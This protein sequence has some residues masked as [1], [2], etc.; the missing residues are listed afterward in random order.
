MLICVDA[1]G[2]R[3]LG[4]GEPQPTDQ[5]FDYFDGHNAFQIPTNHNLTN[6]YCE[7]M[8]LGMQQGYTADMCADEAIKWFERRDDDKPFFPNPSIIE[9]QMSIEKG[10]LRSRETDQDYQQ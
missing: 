9:L 1:F 5:G 3:D 2:R 4:N 6:I 8:A 10:H 7:K